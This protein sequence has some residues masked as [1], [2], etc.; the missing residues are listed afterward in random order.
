MF[1]KRSGC[2][3]DICKNSVKF[4]VLGS[5]RPHKHV[6]ALSLKKMKGSSCPDLHLEV[7]HLK[8]R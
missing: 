7:L 6:R 4:S 1:L 8:I 5:Q 3:G 2:E